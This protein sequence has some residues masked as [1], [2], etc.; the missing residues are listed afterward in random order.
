VVSRLKSSLALNTLVKVPYYARL[1][2][3]HP[4]ELLFFSPRGINWQ[5]G[6]INGLRLKGGRWERGNYLFP[7]TVYNRC[8]P[9]SGK[10]LLGLSELLGEKKVF[11]SLTQFDKWQVYR[12]L[13]RHSTLS[14]YLPKT[15]CYDNGPC[16]MRILS[17]HRAVILKPRLGFGGRGVFLVSKISAELF[18][19]QSHL[20][21]NP[22]LITGEK[23]ASLLFSLSA[24]PA[25]FIAQEYIKSLQ[26]NNTNFD[27]RLL[28]QK[29]YRGEWRAEAA[30]S[31]VCRAGGLLTN[32]YR[33]IV[34]PLQVIEG[35]LLERLEVLSCLTAEQLAG[36]FT[37][38]GEIGVDFLIGEDGRP[39]LLEVNG[40][41]DKSLF[42]QLKQGDVLE[43]IYLNPLAY[44]KF[45][46]GI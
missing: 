26:R 30:L 7:L 2:K 3:R 19:V 27:V 38:L 41:P 11:N 1:S 46:Q 37:S 45:L 34:E 17:R 39:W 6:L 18:K 24:P 31:R 40:K 28:V 20:I 44:Q 15:Y 10:T 36:H 43:R 33:Q 8:Y 5:M 21:R 12:A 25:R 23:F 13:K 4:F 35:P 9:D 16:L 14:A 42:W 22:L 32:D 29:D